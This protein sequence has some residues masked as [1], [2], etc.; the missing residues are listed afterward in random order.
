[1]LS[2]RVFGHP[3]AQSK[4]PFIHQSFA[5]QCEID[6]EYKTQ[7]IALDSFDASVKHFF[8]Q[9]GSGLNVTVPFKEQAF[10]LSD[11]L[12]TEA[13]S[14]GAVN[15]LSYR[16][17]LIYGDNTD[18]YGLVTD[19][20]KQQVPLANKSILLLGAGGAAKGVLLP[21]LQQQPSRLV[22]ANRTLAKATTLAKLYPK[23]PVLALS[24]V[25][26]ADEPFDLIINATSASLMN[27]VPKISSACVNQHTICYDM[28]YGAKPTAF[29][30]WAVAAGC[31]RALDGLGMLVEQAAKSFEL[32]H[33]KVPATST[34]LQQ[35]RVQLNKSGGYSGSAK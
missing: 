5:Q 12:S 13:K 16:Q 19:L 23:S 26:L 3:I 29:S 17:G 1:M 31:S 21:L 10:A 35:L 24:L 18:G 22:I 27:E 28:M 20:I 9:G 25:D 34:V 15:T 33:G 11:V 7:L 14:A 2:F 32:W 8:R 4:S 6:L 30:R